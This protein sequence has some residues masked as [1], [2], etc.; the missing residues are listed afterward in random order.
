[1]SVMSHIRGIKS[2][3]PCQFRDAP[4]PDST[5]QSADAHY[6]YKQKLKSTM[7]QISDN[8]ATAQNPQ[9]RSAPPVR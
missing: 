3:R 6:C 4:N 5:L 2:E 1:M 8:D 9:S 7:L